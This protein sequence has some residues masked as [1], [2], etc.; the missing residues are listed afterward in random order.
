MQAVFNWREMR[1]RGLSSGFEELAEKGRGFVGEDAGR[2]GQ[3][4]IHT[5][6]VEDGEAGANCAAL[7]IVRTVDEAID[8]GLEH[9]ARAHRAGLD[10]DVESESRETMIPHS[11][12]GCAQGDYFRVR[13]RVAVCDGT[14]A[15][16][17][18]DIFPPTMTQ[19]TG[20][21]PFCAARRAS[22]SAS[23]M[24]S[25]SRATCSAVSLASFIAHQ[26]NMGVSPRIA[27]RSIRVRARDRLLEKVRRCAFDAFITG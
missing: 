5:R 22:A 26:N 11:R 1:K 7:G 20:T 21:S 23:R 12:C 16:A 9:C 13:G 15:G 24:Y 25:S 2:D 27:A 19:P 18:E 4:V 8:P 17:R 3:A 10:S 14:I 6:M